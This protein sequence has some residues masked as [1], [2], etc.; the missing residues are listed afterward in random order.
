VDEN[1]I[2]LIRP[3]MAG[4]QIDT[5]GPKVKEPRF[6]FE[7]MTDLRSMPALE[8]LID[9]W[10]PERSVGL[11]YGR[12][13]TFKTFIG[14]DWALH[15]AYGRRDW[16]GAK[17]PGTPCDVLIIAR[18]GHAGFVKRVSAFMAHHGIESDPERLTF[19]RSSISFVDNSDFGAL[20]KSVKVLDRPFRFVLVDTVGRVLPG[21][22]MGKEAPITLFM[23]RL[24]QLGEVTNAT[25]LGVHHENKGGD[26]N[27]SMFFQNSSDFM[28]NSEREGKGETG[29]ITCT[30]SK[31]GTDGWSK[32]IKFAKVWLPDGRSSLVVESVFDNDSSSAKEE[33]LTKNEATFYRILYDAGADGLTKEE[34]NKLGREAGLG[35]N[36]RSDLQ[37]FRVALRDK[38]RVRE[39]G[40][41]WKV[42]HG[43]GLS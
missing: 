14:F 38:G 2:P 13:G 24:Q 19:M 17:L 23:E 27:G 1:I 6:L 33:I 3:A 18:E 39:Y 30:K 15:L 41:K 43:G 42:N 12:W 4:E 25:S 36:R 34:W 7:T 10:I 40:G 35:L 8:H 28:F 31:E 5:S 11:L 20:K 26:A 16:R 32:G 9:G 29:K 37:D 22:E 21:V